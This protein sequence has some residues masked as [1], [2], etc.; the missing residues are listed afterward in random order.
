[1]IDETGDA[2]GDTGE[3][4]LVTYTEIDGNVTDTN[5]LTAPDQTITA[6]DGAAPLIIRAV[7]G[8]TDTFGMEGFGFVDQII[9]TFSEPITTVGAVVSGGYSIV[10]ADNTIFA[11]VMIIGV[12]EN[13]TRSVILEIDDG[14]AAMTRFGTG[15]ESAVF[16]GLRCR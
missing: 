2:S 15:L 9:L 16:R 11:D 12:T 14:A 4:L 3:N 13:N 10:M 5:S 6:I 1:M 8:D 7:N